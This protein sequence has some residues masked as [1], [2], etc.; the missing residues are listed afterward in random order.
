MVVF[1]KISSIFFIYNHLKDC[2]ALH[3]EKRLCHAIKNMYLRLADR[4]PNVTVGNNNF[5][6]Y[7]WIL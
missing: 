3:L 5:K 6:G 7:L 2:S 4:I 1:E